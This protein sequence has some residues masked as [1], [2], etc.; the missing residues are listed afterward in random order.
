MPEYESGD[1][2]IARQRADQLDREIT[3][4]LAGRPSPTTDAEVLWLAAAL[5]P[6]PS[7]SLGRRVDAVVAAYP[8]RSWR[9]LQV[10]AAA[11]AAVL[12]AQGLSNVGW[13]DWV[14]ENLGEAPSPHASV[15]GGL[16]LL[17]VAVAVAAGAFRRRWMAASVMAGGPLG[18][19]LGVRGIGEVGEF[20]GGAVLHLAEGC[21]GAALLVAWWRY[22]RDGGADPGE[23]G[24]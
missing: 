7:A 3:A 24:A 21:L 4:A 23:V 12:A 13:G 2:P 1:D 20:P 16:A 17:A 10:V 22:R 19:V 9:V 6:E 11:L 8:T 15:E 18:V 5:R 14:A